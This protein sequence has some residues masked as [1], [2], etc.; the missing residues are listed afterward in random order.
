M[1]LRRILA[2]IA[3]VLLSTEVL[4]PSSA[5]VREGELPQPILSTSQVVK[6]QQA[7]A[8]RGGCSAWTAAGDDSLGP[9]APEFAVHSALV[10]SLTFDPGVAAALPLS[11]AGLESVEDPFLACEIRPPIAG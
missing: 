9:D 4:E 10:S 3:L 11:P 6:K 8:P 1:K 7:S 5:F 2:L